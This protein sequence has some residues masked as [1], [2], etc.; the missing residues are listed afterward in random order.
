MSGLSASASPRSLV[1][2]DELAVEELAARL[3]RFGTGAAEAAGE[4]RQVQAGSWVGEAA[5]AFR[6][7]VGDLPRRL[8]RG[9]D[10]FFAAQQALDAYAA[11]VRQARL[12]AARAIDA[13]ADGERASAQWRL[14]VQA[15]DRAQR[16]ADLTAVLTGVPV[17]PPSGP[18]PS[19]VDPGDDD[20]ATAQ[21]LLD[22]ARDE[23]DATA[24][25]ATSVLREAA[26]AAPD[27]PSWLS[28]A[29]GQVGQFF[30]GAGEA[31]WDMVEFA[32]K[33][34]PTYALIDPEG[35]VE[36]GRSLAEGLVYAV[37]NP[38]EFA[39]AVLDWETWK[40]NPARALGRLVPDLLLTVATGGA[41][42]SVRAA[43]GVEAAGD[44]AGVR[45]AGGAPIGGPR[46]TTGPDGARVYGL[47]GGR[48]HR[49]AAAPEQFGTRGSAREVVDDALS[50][51]E[52][53]A[54][55]GV[56]PWTRQDLIDRIGTPA[57][58]LT[59]A[60]AA[61][62]N[63]IRDRVPVPGAGDWMQKVLTPQAAS[64]Y[65]ANLADVRRGPT[66]A[67]GSVTRAVDTAHLGTPGALHDSLRLDYPGTPF[68]PAADA[69]HV[70]RFQTDTPDFDIPRS[71]HLGGSGRF[72]TWSD[73]FTGN[74]FTKAG[75]D[76]VPE[77]QTRTSVDMT[78]GA[79]MWEVLE[80]GTQRLAAVLVDKTWVPVGGRAVP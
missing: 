15:H 11:Q 12:V 79:E 69:V 32:W 43:R 2:G 60:D 74:G 7:Q 47:D 18:R 25:Q 50:D 39:K 1:P 78:P 16:T 22:G 70:L 63:A 57:A 61:V 8:D 54:G 66:T 52:L 49:A 41:G 56:E 24:R 45:H 3:S 5:D 44:L 55:H 38:V 34:T 23:V 62:L 28:R 29:A 51:R 42:A 4:L 48:P 71:S 19:S 27:E 35:F 77:W 72:D 9:A 75:D 58:D 33:L 65:L 21:R 10:A 31:T 59:P 67:G 80:T 68:Q 53:F 40:E 37:Q 64:D 13:W 17:V 14:Q 36:N 73:P 46:V 6:E 76:L 26:E 20:R 30:A